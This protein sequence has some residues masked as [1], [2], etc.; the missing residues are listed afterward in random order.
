MTYDEIVASGKKAVVLFTSVTCGPCKRL[1]PRLAALAEARG[2][3]LHILD[4]AQEM[5][6]VRALGLRGVPA[7]LT[8][9]NQLA[10]LQFQGDRTDEQIIDTLQR[11]G[12]IA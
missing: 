11:A 10:V 6:A 1:K 2:F 7:L 5:P 3:E 4:I 12:V 8:T 9:E